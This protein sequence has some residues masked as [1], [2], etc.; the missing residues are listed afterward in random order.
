LAKV[1]REASCIEDQTSSQALE[2]NFYSIHLF[3]MLTFKRRFTVETIKTKVCPVLND[4][5]SALVG[6]SVF[7]VPPTITNQATS[8]SDNKNNPIPI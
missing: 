5:Q 3:K 4:V 7:H 8:K 1:I 6:R 2:E